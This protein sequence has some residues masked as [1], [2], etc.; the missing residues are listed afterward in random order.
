M[1]S[2]AH[3]EH[4]ANKNK[5]AIDSAISACDAGTGTNSKWPATVISHLVSKFSQN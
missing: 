5:A 4:Q 3:F 1:W 2:H